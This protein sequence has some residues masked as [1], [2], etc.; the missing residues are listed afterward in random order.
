MT[1][2]A[3]RAALRTAGFP[4]EVSQTA[5]TY[6]CNHVFYGLMHAVRARR[7][8]RAGFIHIPYSPAQAA[9]HPGAPSLA[10]ETVTEALRLAVQV[11]LKTH[12]DARLAAGAEH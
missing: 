11:A 7:G 5:G 2:K 12:H 6:L 9:V 8:L 3:M 1:I 10:V 4:A